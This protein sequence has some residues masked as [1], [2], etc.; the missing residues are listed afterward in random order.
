MQE[1]YKAIADPTRRRI[2][3]YL[4]GGER[5]A[6]ELAEH[7]GIARTA[8]SHHLTM[9]KLADLVR[10]ER[11]GQFQIYTLNTTVFQDLMAEVLGWFGGIE[12]SP[13]ESAGEPEEPSHVSREDTAL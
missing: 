10:V 7:A 6:G 13:T 12:T 3:K 2:L 11:R 9:L 4:R 8:L 5:T 1:A